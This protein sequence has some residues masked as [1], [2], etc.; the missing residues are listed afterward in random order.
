MVDMG[1]LETR[2]EGEQRIAVGAE[3][4]LDTLL[5]AAVPSSL[6]HR[7]VTDIA[8]ADALASFE[9]AMVVLTRMT[10]MLPI[11]PKPLIS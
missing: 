5:V 7:I 8:V 4:T 2:R 10:K 9:L 3:V 11:V 1:A 6:V